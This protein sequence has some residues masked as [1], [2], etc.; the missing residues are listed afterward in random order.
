M[1]PSEDSNA[2]PGQDELEALPPGE[3][4]AAELEAY[5]ARNSQR[6]EALARLQPAPQRSLEQA[7]EE[8]EIVDGGMLDLEDVDGSADPEAA[9]RE[10]ASSAVSPGALT[11]GGRTLRLAAS[12]P[13]GEA[14]EEPVAVPI[15]RTPGRWWVLGLA[16]AAALALLVGIGVALAPQG[17]TPLG[18]PSVPPS[19]TSTAPLPSAPATSAVP[20]APAPSASVAPA[21]PATGSA[22]APAP[23]AAPPVPSP[24]S[25]RD[26][27]APSAPVKPPTP[28]STVGPLFDNDD[29]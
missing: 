13:D 9:R 11:V 2:F 12:S 10:H 1:Y 17:G 16:A 20:M 28:L 29:E 25:K 24:A 3:A 18:A 7:R 22:P 15:H 5:V 21:A 19:D 4:P 8:T 6:F 27:G 14:P 23:S 26:G